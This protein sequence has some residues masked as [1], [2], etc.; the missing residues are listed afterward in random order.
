MGASCVHGVGGLW[1]MTAV[2]IFAKKV[3]FFRVTQW[4]RIVS[5]LSLHKL[6]L[7]IK[8]AMQVLERADLTLLQ[9]QLRG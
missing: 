7:K 1:G 2:G 9:G 4:Y 5:A 6:L 3:F 8:H